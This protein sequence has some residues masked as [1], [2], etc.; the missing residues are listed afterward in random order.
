MGLAPNDVKKMTVWEFIAVADHWMEAHDTGDD[1]KLSA[2]E[3]DEIWD[4][5]QQKDPVPVS[6]RKSNGHG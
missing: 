3:A 5:M 2:A 4:W 6:S 1:R